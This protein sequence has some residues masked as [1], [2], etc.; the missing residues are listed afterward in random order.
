MQNSFPFQNLPILVQCKILRQYIPFFCKT[1]VLSHLPEFSKLLNDRYSWLNL[2]ETSINLSR[3]LQHLSTGMYWNLEQGIGY[4]VF[5]DSENIS[6]TLYSLQK[7]SLYHFVFAIFYPLYNEEMSISFQTM[8]DFLM[9][10][11][12]KYFTFKRQVYI[13][14]LNQGDYVYINYLNKKVYWN[15]KVYTIKDKKCIIELDLLEKCII[16]LKDDRVEV[17]YQNANF[18][19]PTKEIE[20]QTL[21]SFIFNSHEKQVY[22][23]NK[24]LEMNFR[25]LEDHMH[26]NLNLPVKLNLYS[27]PSYPR[28]LNKFHHLKQNFNELDILFN[29][30][31]PCMYCIQKNAN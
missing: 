20:P 15:N 14:K 7:D 5:I 10:F 4:Y 2:S 25:L 30:F 1:F 18:E 11:L 19:Q 16:N 17:I 6:F 12:N 9:L 13:Y 29:P 27:I 24:I 28:Q 21:E 23:C 8:Q 22:N 31:R 26:L 3:I